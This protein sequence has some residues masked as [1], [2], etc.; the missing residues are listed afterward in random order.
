MIKVT[1]QEIQPH[2]DDKIEFILVKVIFS[3]TD[4]PPY[5]S[6]TVEI[7][8]PK[9]MDQSLTEIRDQAILKADSFLVRLREGR[10]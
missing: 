3:D 7:F 1:V 10:D 4:G 8:L 6:A 9:K 2:Y 5:D